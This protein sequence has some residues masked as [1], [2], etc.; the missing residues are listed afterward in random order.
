[1]NQV[2]T[3][4]PLIDKT[5]TPAPVP[6]IGPGL[7]PAKG[8]GPAPFA[9]IYADV[10]LGT[11]FY[12]QWLMDTDY[13]TDEGTRSVPT[14]GNPE[15]VKLHEP[16]TTKIIK[17]TAERNGAWPVLPHWD[18]G[19]PN[20]VLRKKRITPANPL[21][22][23]NQYIYRVTGLYIYDL[24]VP[25]GENDSMPAGHSPADLATPAMTTLTP[26]QFDKTLAASAPPLP[27]GPAP[28]PETPKWQDP[29]AQ[30]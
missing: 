20:E 22:G 26:D 9:A 3:E 2:Q 17:W 15:I 14:D 7:I 11:Q 30:Q 16:I 1:M 27:P 29:L 23:A 10:Q 25:L 12:N 8:Q 19:N 21:L 5:A 13:E 18:T 6:D 4:N 28:A 24:R